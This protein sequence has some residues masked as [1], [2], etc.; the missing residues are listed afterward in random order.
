MNKDV[1][2]RVA[3]LVAVVAAALLLVRATQPREWEYIIL[4]PSDEAFLATVQ[5]A[6]A[7]GWEL[8]SAR[9]ANDS[10]TEKFGYEM[11]FKRPKGSVLISPPLQAAMMI[12]QSTG[13]VP[14]DGSVLLT[15]ETKRF[16]NPACSLV[17]DKTYLT[18]TTRKKAID[19]DY[20]ACE[21]CNP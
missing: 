5:N 10:V 21:I 9:R 4:S 2:I 11:I 17:F 18:K 1:V 14:S 7:Q 20:Q 8:V 6:G 16:H 12:P 19:Q 3:T 13:A 15:S